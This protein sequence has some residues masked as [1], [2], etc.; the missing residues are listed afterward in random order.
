MRH[1]PQSLA[2]L[3]LGVSAAAQCAEPEIYRCAQDD[4]TFAFQQTPCAPAVADEP[5]VDQPEE[6][7]DDFFEFENPFDAPQEPPQQE[8]ATPSLPSDDRQQCEKQTRDAIDA[9]DL[10][11][12]QSN[13]KEDDRSH[14]RE[15]LELTRQ[16]RQCKQL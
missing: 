5:A 11:L 4:G 13:S 15:L 10:K 14:L 7:G 8:P 12:Q 6:T 1:A 3:L 16:L 2:L 9:I